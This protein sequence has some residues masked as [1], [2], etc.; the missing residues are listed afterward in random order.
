MSDFE[1]DFE[2]PV[3]AKYEFRPAS[4]EEIR[5]VEKWE[6]YDIP[7]W[8]SQGMPEA[9]L[10]L[11]LGQIVPS[12]QIRNHRPKPEAMELAV[13]ALVECEKTPIHTVALKVTRAIG[14][15]SGKI[16]QTDHELARHA[17]TI[18]AL[19]GKIAQTKPD[20]GDI[21]INWYSVRLRLR[22]MFE[23]K[24]NEFTWPHPAV[25]YKGNLGIYLIPD[26]DNKPL[27]ALRPANLE[28]ALVLYAAR[29][30]AT[31]TTFN[32]CEHCKTPFLSGGT[33]F[34]NK[35]GDARFC[36]SACRW[37]WHNESRRKTR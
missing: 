13:K 18:R 7:R 23:G 37:K 27:L 14:A 31:G 8:R 32:I 33:R 9:E 2:W 24:Y 17:R 6:F 22:W 34:R 29:M 11:V 19:S 26:K 21:L 10:P 36:S 20:R 35:R 16:S 25:Q 3:A 5:E 4:A 30:I 1:I 28:D 12:G 15:L